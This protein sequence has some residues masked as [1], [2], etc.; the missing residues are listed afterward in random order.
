MRRGPGGNEPTI[1]LD[2]MKAGKSFEEAVRDVEILHGFICEE[3][4]KELNK[5]VLEKQVAPPAKKV[6]PLK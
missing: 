4:W 6:D 1:I 2:K 5:P 3:W